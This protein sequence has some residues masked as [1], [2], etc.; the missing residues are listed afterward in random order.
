M[1]AEEILD[2]SLQLERLH[3]RMTGSETAPFASSIPDEITA[4]HEPSRLRGFA[5]Y[6]LD[7]LGRKMAVEFDHTAGTDLAPTE[8]EILY[9]LTRV[10]PDIVLPVVSG[11]RYTCRNDHLASH[12]LRWWMYQYGPTDGAL[13]AASEHIEKCDLLPDEALTM[14]VIRGQTQAHEMIPALLRWLGSRNESVSRRAANVLGFLYVLVPGTDQAAFISEVESAL[15]QHNWLDGWQP[16]KDGTTDGRRWRS[17][18]SAKQNP[19]L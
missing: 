13:W 19:T 1:S 18:Q 15:R 11:W 12:V 7:Y 10:L 2:L 17:S 5:R 8:T 4:C 14:R 3:R 16:F 9:A 6:F